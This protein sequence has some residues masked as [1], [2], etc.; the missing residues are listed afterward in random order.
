MNKPKENKVQQVV[1]KR[2]P[3]TNQIV[4]SDMADAIEAWMK[5]INN[6]EWRGMKYAR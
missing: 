1:V 4:Q 3:G 5:R 2:V 6:T